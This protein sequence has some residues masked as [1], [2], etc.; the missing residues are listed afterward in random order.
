MRHIHVIAPARRPTDKVRLFKPDGDATLSPSRSHPPVRVDATPYS[1]YSTLNLRPI[2]AAM[3]L[4]KITYYKLLTPE[5]RAEIRAAEEAHVACRATHI[6]VGWRSRWR[7]TPRRRLASPLR[8]THCDRAEMRAT[9]EARIMRRAARIAI[10]L[11][12]DSSDEEVEVPE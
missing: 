1:L 9:E 10:S 5:N 4:N 11:P 2:D 3:V 12:P 7:C 6:M 8:R